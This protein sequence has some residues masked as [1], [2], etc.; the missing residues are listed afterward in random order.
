MK[1]AHIITRLIVGGAQENTIFTVEGLK[2]KGYTVDLIS[3]HTTG[4]EGSLVKR[5]K[6]ADIPLFINSSIT[7]NINPFYDIPAFLKLLFFLKKRHYDIVHTHSAKAGILGRIAAGIVSRKTIVIHTVHGLSFHDYQSNLRNSFYIFAERLAAKFTDHFICVGNVMKE[8]CLNAD[9]GKKAQ[10]SVIYSG[11]KIKPY[12]EASSKRRQERER[13]GIKPEEKVIGM[14]GRLFP[15]K[16]QNYL[17]R[18]FCEIVK[19]FPESKLLLI[20]DGILRKN[21]E[22]YAKKEGLEK[23]VIFT[24]LVPPQKIPD[25]VAAMDIL[26]HT[27]LREGL[28][29]AVA[30]GF[31]GGKPVVGFDVDGTRE[32]VKEGITGF[33]IPPRNVKHLKEKLLFLLQNSEI[34]CKMGNRGRKIVEEFFPVEKMVEEIEK[35]YLQLTEKKLL[36]IKTNSEHDRKKS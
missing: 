6:Q 18:A 3:G 27:S 28:P 1:I 19:T 14:I 8:K 4:P 32:L 35:I 33:L 15:L 13:L 24:G 26:A 9:I 29:K 5:I 23:K 31:A 36:K 25:L 21:L 2:K 10:Y 7:R 20:G 11:F 12:L 34:A 22:N 30:Q 16:G 17:M